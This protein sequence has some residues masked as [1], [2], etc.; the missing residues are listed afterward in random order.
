MDL[1]QKKT[2]S[3]IRNSFIELRSKKPLEKITVKELTEAAEISKATFYLHYQDIYDLSEALQND[4]I[5]N[6]FNNIEHPEYVIENTGVFARELFN[7]FAANQALIDIL[8]SDNQASVLPKQIE[9]KI[10]EVILNNHPEFKDDVKFQIFLTYAV[11]G[12]YYA[13]IDNK[14]DF[15]QNV[16]I[17]AI[18]DFSSSI[19]PILTCEKNN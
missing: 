19:P 3:A 15:A 7:A 1:R 10:R 4:T 18:A 6:V 11:L 9:A 13:Y 14:K 12:G 16:L 2:L 8:F 17:D 5:Q